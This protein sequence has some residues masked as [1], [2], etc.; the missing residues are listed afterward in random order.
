MSKWIRTLG[1]IAA[2]L[3]A[4][5]TQAGEIAVIAH[6]STKIPGVSEKTL[7]DIYL[8]R[9]KF[10]PDG[11]RVTP[12]DQPDGSRIRE[13]FYRAVADMNERELNRYWSKRVFTGKGRAPRAL[14]NDAEVL[15]YVA[16][17]PG[18]L[19]YID[20]TNLDASVEVLL[21]IP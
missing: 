3:A 18:S 16:D 7:A 2:L 5:A 14:D 1:L 6:P 17:N 13:R 11:S 12:I 4:S 20:G 19:G 10:L 8:G 9:I 21:I 15:E